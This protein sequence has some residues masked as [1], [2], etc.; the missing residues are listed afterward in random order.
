MAA[1]VGNV[2][3]GLET[4]ITRDGS[5]IAYTFTLKDG[6][7][8]EVRVP[9]GHLAALILVMEQKAGD[10]IKVYQESLHGVDRRFFELRPRVVSKLQGAAVDGKPILSLELDG[11]L[12]LDLSFS[13]SQVAAL[14]EWLEE[15]QQRSQQKQR[16]Q[17]PS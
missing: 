9:V 7:R 15:L 1:V 16:Q 14:I 8:H 2:L 5:Q 17:L 6:S 12:V 13:Q 3:E 10:A 4:D 11:K